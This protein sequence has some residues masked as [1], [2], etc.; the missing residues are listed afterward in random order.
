MNLNLTTITLGLKW[1]PT[2]NSFDKKL[3]AEGIQTASQN[4]GAVLHLHT[5]LLHLC[6]YAETTRRDQLRQKCVVY[7]AKNV[8]G[9]LL[10]IPAGHVHIRDS[11]ATFTPGM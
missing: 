8:I 7:S 4:H 6:Q 3:A 2:I 10:S 1:E 9:H 5:D 11:D